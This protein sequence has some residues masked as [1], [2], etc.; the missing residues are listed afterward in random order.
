MKRDKKPPTIGADAIKN[1]RLRAVTERIEKRIQSNAENADRQRF[2]QAF[3]STRELKARY[4]EAV[5]RYREFA[6]AMA[7]EEKTLFDGRKPI[8]LAPFTMMPLDVLTNPDLSD[9]AKIVYGMLIHYHFL[10]RSGCFAAQSTLAKDLHTSIRTVQRG[11]QELWKHRLI[12]ISYRKSPSGKVTNLYILNIS[13][14]RT[15]EG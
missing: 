12:N 8:Q 14:N 11:L 2:A 9:R 7:A 1:P 15:K 4:E 3:R 6:R 5:T 13:D 10:R